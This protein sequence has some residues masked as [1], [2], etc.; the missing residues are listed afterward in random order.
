M[1]FR[2]KA[3]PGSN[4][5]LLPTWTTSPAAAARSRSSRH[6][7]IVVPS[8]FSTSTCLPAAIALSAAGDVEL[9]G[10]GDDD[11]L[12]LGVGQHRVV[13]G[14]G[15]LGL[16]HRLHSPPQV[17]GQVAD[18]VELGV[19]GLAAGVEVRELGDRPAAQHADPQAALVLGDHAIF[20]G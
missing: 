19:S 3:M 16:V 20:P 15:D 6:D 10:D 5:R 18:R 12:D 11:R 8:G 9:V 13:V 4:R 17:V 14:V 7:S 2:A 1:N